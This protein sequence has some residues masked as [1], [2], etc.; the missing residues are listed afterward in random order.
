MKNRT[1]F[2]TTSSLNT[3]TTNVGTKDN[4]LSSFWTEHLVEEH[5]DSVENKLQCGGLAV[6]EGWQLTVF[7]EENKKCYFGM[8][9]PDPDNKLTIED[10]TLRQIGINTDQLGDFMTDT[11]VTR[12]SN[13]YYYYTYVRFAHPKNERHC[14]IH[15]FFDSES[16][17]DF[18]NVVGNYC[19]LGNFNQDTHAYHVTNTVTTYIYKGKSIM[20]N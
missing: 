20:C 8:I 3:I 5:S 1:I 16:K 18:F 2:A 13:L 4:V 12:Q 15:C 7:D 9:N 6:E 14:G 10:G 19:Y 11:F 17:C